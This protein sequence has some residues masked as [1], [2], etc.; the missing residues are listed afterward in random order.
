MISRVK[1]WR[2]G[3]RDALPMPLFLWVCNLKAIAKGYPSRVESVSGT[4]RMRVSDKTG[5]IEVCR[6]SR[7]WLYKRSVARRLSLLQHTY[8]L[9]AL[10]VIPGGAFIDCGANIGELGWY[11]RAKGLDY[12]PFEPEALEADCCDANN[13]AGEPRTNRLAL[14][15][16]TTT[17]TFYSKPNSGDSSVFE[18]DH[19]VDRRD[20]PAVTLDD[21]VARAGI[22]RV[23]VLKV[24]AEG[25]EPEV[26]AGARSTLERTHYVTVD[27]GFERG[28][29]AASTA[30]PVINF[31]MERGFRL[32]EWNADRI[33]FLFERVR[34]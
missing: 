27:C 6:R 2:D 23:A 10:D 4:A 14:W 13:F 18:V 28:L 24:E 5:A 33:T 20:V 25:A 29:E 11:A 22:D 16:E 34:G 15:S 31:L 19:F 7:L 21:Y 9:D 12:H 8:M 17:L 3:F 30:V 26:L 1:R 32:R